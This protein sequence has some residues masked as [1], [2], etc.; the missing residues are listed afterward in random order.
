MTLELV[1]ATPVQTETPTPSVTL[2]RTPGPA[3]IINEILADPDTVLGDSNRDGVISSDDDEF[4]ELV[5]DRQQLLDLS[6]WRVE[7]AV[8]VRYIFPGGTTLSPGC[9]LVIFGGGDP[10]GDFGGSLVFTAGSLGLN[11]GGDLIVVR[12][13]E[14]NEVALV[15]YGSEGNHNQSLTRYPDLY[16][17]L[18]F[19]LHSQLLEAG[20]ELF[21]PGTRIDQTVFGTCP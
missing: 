4:L 21:S 6:G 10:R 8:R 1:T 20:E 7:D 16:G 5:N 14:G 2:T 3:L 11:N 13:F 9:G 19:V 15:Q 18:P 12:D 17:P